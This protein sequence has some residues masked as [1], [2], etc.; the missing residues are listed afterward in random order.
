MAR[1]ASLGIRH[2]WI[3]EHDVRMGHWKHPVSSFA[4]REGGLWEQDALGGYGF[5]EAEGNSGSYAVREED[6]ERRLFLQANSGE[7]EELLFSSKGKRHC[8]ALFAKPTVTLRGEARPPESGRLLLTFHLSQQPPHYKQAR[9]AFYLGDPPEKEEGLWALPLPAA[10][11]GGWHFPLWELVP[12]EIGGLDNALCSLSLSVESKAGRGEWIL[13]QVSFSKEITAEPLRQRQIALA[14]KLGKK[15]GVK[16]FVG[17]EISGAGQHK[18]CYSTKVPVPDYAAH[19]FSLSEEAAVAHVL[20][21]GGIFSYNH[22]FTPWKRKKLSEEEKEAVVAQRAE[23]LLANRALGATLLEVGFPEE[24]E[25]FAGAYY[26]QLWDL[27]ALGG[28]FLTGDGDSDHHGCGEVG[29]LRGNNFCSYVGVP[30]GEDLTEENFR[31]A[32]CRGNLYMGD[33]TV[34]GNVEFTADGAPMGSVLVGDA[35][36]V[37][38]RA[39]AMR[40]DG[41]CR[42][43]LNGRAAGEMPIK[44]GKALWEF[45]LSGTE[46][47]NFARMELYDADGRL[48]ALTNPIYLVRSE[49][50]IPEEAKIRRM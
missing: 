10:E 1:A 13:S 50:D 25:G 37:P 28:L 43:I 38:F 4:F 39:E 15:H 12:E 29:W 6:G 26:R 5:T 7:R 27:L 47:F 11:E 36:K 34:L 46:R 22:P 19:Q 31:D 48:V 42:R 30:A 9:L 3:T 8:D 32:V 23:A 21:Q 2:L 17:F 33:P 18:N 45:S 44:E 40:F 49:K 20:S 14:E 41:F 16:A 24:K 35:C